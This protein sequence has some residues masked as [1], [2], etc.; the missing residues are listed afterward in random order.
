MYSLTNEFEKIP[1]EKG[2]GTIIAVDFYSFTART[3]HW[4]TIKNFAPFSLLRREGFS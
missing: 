1:F 2:R 4:P 3:S